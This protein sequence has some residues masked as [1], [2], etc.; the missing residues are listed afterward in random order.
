[1][2]MWAFIAG[3]IVTL[4][5]LAGAGYAALESGAIPAN[6]DAKPGGFELWAAGASLHATLNREAPKG[7]NPVPLTEAN[8]AEGV[9]LYAQNCVVC[10]GDAAG[11]AARSPVAKG[12]Y[13]QP[14]QF[15]SDGVEDDPEGVTFWKVKHGIRL[16]GMPSWRYALTDQQIW[17]VAL[18]L[19]HMDKLPAAVDQAWR[20]VHD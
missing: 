10:H 18:F 8:L 4:I 5:V 17:T 19:K 16:T 20:Q 9:R 12:L 11:E 15:A 14:P 6:A 7:P 3:V 2:G 1:M 13:P